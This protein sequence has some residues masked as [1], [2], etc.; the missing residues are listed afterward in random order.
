[1]LAMMLLIWVGGPLA[2]I[3]ALYGLLLIGQTAQ[4]L[5]FPPSP[6]QRMRQNRMYLTLSQPQ[7]RRRPPRLPNLPPGRN[8]SRPRPKAPLGRY[9]TSYRPERR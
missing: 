2:L 9:A 5:L 3:S 6:R 1:M 4:R 7:I 8:G